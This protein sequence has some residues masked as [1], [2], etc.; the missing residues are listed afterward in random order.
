M[1]EGP[2]LCLTTPSHGFI[3]ESA[4][5]YPREGDLEQEGSD[6]DS[7]GAGGAGDDV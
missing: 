3:L 7:R 1:R 6:A 2:A 4:Y 5:P